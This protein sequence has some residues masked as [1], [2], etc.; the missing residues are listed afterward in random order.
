MAHKGRIEMI[1]FIASCVVSVCAVLVA[2]ANDSVSMLEVDASIAHPRPSK[3]TNKNLGHGNQPH[4]H[5][6]PEAQPWVLH[7]LIN[8][9]STPC[10]RSTT[11]PQGLDLP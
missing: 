9:I 3:N 4:H 8:A 2:V 1:L 7:V 6:A 11:K 10:A 5:S